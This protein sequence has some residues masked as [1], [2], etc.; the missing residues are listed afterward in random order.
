MRRMSS[1][2]ASS[3]RCWISFERAFADHQPRLEVI[4]PRDQNERLAVVDIAEQLLGI[5]AGAADAE[6]QHVDGNAELLHLEAGGLADARVTAIAAD[7]QIGQDIDR[8]IRR[9][10]HHA[11]NASIG[12]RS[13]PA[14]SFC[15]RRVK[16]G[17]LLRLVGEE[18]E[19][20]PLRH[21][22]DELAVRR[23]TAE[24]GGVKGVIAENATGR[25]SASDAE[26]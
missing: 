7:D 10:R 20:V 23:Q 2:K 18:V 5:V 6:P 14:A 19:K 11:A 8:A 25:R 16:L 13:G 12:R 26:P 21:E 9:L 15:M 24:V 17:K 1:R 4:A 3:P 22:R